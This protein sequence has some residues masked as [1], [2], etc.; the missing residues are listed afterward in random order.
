MTG[1]LD[2]VVAMG[3]A[4]PATRCVDFSGVLYFLDGHSGFVSEL[5]SVSLFAILSRS[6]R[7]HGFVLCANFRCSVS[8]LIRAKQPTIA[9]RLPDNA[10]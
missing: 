5:F 9:A 2:Q 6:F 4:V 10:D 3:G 8:L 7:F 1:G